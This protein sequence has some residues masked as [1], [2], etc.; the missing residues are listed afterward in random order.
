MNV[1]QILLCG[2]WDQASFVSDL[3][4]GQTR[5][6]QNLSN[7]RHLVS[8]QTNFQMVFLSFGVIVGVQLFRYTA[9]F[10]ASAQNFNGIC[11]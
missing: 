3:G 5:H 9:M 6:F 8:S 7:L 2:S 4:C 10:T 1:R 11:A